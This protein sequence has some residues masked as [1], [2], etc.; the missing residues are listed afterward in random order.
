MSFPW[1]KRWKLT[2]N[3]P[4]LRRVSLESAAV[5]LFSDDLAHDCESDGILARAG[6]PLTLNEIR[7][8]LRIEA[9]T[10]SR[11]AKELFSIGLWMQEDDGSVS[12][13]HIEGFSTYIQ[14]PEETQ[15]SEDERET[16]APGEESSPQQPAKKVASTRGRGGRP[17]SGQPS[18][19][20]LKMRELREQTAL[21]NGN[22]LG[23]K[24]TQIQEQTPSQTDTNSGNKPTQTHVSPHTPLQEKTREIEITEEGNEE[25][26][27]GNELPQTTARDAHKPTQN[28]SQTSEQTPTQTGASEFSPGYAFNRRFVEIGLEV[29]AFDASWRLMPESLVVSQS[30]KVAAAMVETHG[31]EECER[32]ARRFLEAWAKGQTWGRKLTVSEFHARWDWEVASGKPRPEA[33]P[34]R[35]VNRRPPKVVPGFDPMAGFNDPLAPDDD[36][37]ESAGGAQ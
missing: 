7:E 6:I 10:F 20:A 13:L 35:P 28:R 36:E 12:V 29:G 3:Y 26:T 34:S 25:K 11:A 19:R 37:Q 22:K 24:P 18:K 16:S 31:F 9:F 33:N 21:T 27:E 4:L 23:H 30:L 14:E 8:E 15:E 1:Y 17:R 2:R 32:R 5:Y